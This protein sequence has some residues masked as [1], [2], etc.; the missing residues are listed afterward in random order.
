MPHIDCTEQVQGLL[1][2]DELQELDLHSRA[3]SDGQV[4]AGLTLMFRLRSL[5]RELLTGNRIRLDLTL[6]GSQTRQSGVESPLQDALVGLSK[7]LITRG[8]FVVTHGTERSPGEDTR[9]V[10]WDGEAV[11]NDRLQLDE[12]WMVKVRE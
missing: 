2:E 6:V 9:L 12:A 7:A 3:L 10:M 5:V 8:G 1:T 4:Q 11:P